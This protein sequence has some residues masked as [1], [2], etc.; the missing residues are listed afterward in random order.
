MRVPFGALVGLLAL[1][2]ACG[3]DEPQLL[4]SPGC[5]DPRHPE[6][7]P[8][9]GWL[10]EGAPEWSPL[11]GIVDQGTSSRALDA[12]AGR[13]REVLGRGYNVTRTTEDGGDCVRARSIVLTGPSRAVVVV[14]A[15]QLQQPVDPFL[16]VR[17]PRRVPAPDGGHLVLDE[18]DDYRSATLAVY[19]APDG[20]ALY[21]RARSASSPSISG[22][23]TTTVPLTVS[24]APPGPSPFTAEELGDIG[25]RIAAV[26]A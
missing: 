14:V 25:M 22:W 9:N 15:M 6:P 13:V 26:V 2:G 3:D 23:P 5:L 17:N 19:V 16:P 8:A 7:A 20:L 21:V 10:V 4:A 18:Y 12:F 24:S 1:V 11:S